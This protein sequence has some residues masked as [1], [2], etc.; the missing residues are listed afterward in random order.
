MPEG[1][2]QSLPEVAGR[3]VL[4]LGC[5][6]GYGSVWMKRLGARRTVGL[7]N[8]PRQLG[9][10][11]LLQTEFEE[12]FPLVHADAERLPFASASFDVAISEYGASIWCDPQRWIPE[13]ARVL[14]P[15]GRLWFLRNATLLMLCMPEYEAEG[16]KEALLRPQFGMSRFDWPDEVGVEFHL[17]HGRL[18]AL[19]RRCGFEIEALHELE[20]P[21]D[22]ASRFQF[23]DA[24]WASR[25][26]SEEIWLVRKQRGPEGEP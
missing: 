10:A 3:D 13:A 8:S 12:P 22:A 15:G 7:D 17:P 5:G 19:L 4:E 21:A 11:A 26:P 1:E 2:L 14:R 6:T 20:A 16:T 25:W 24:D 9:T 18:I 23:V